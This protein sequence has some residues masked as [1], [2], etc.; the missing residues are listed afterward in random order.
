M[1]NMSFKGRW[2]LVTGASSGLGEAMA[3]Q[4]AAEQAHLMLVARRADKLE[5]LKDELQQQHGIDCRVL[6]ADL[7]QENEIERLHREAEAIGPVYGLILNAGITHFGPHTDLSWSG[8][9]QLLSTNV[10]SVVHLIERFLPAMRARADGS[11]I[12]L[13][14]SLGGLIPVPLQA[15]YSG[16][17]GF[18]CNFGLA[19]AEELRKEAV[20]VTVYC[21][22]GIETPMS[23]DSQLKF[24]KNTPFMQDVDSC[25]ADGLSAMRKR[26]SLFVPGFLNRAQL[27]ATRLAPRSLVNRLT[28]NTYLR[29]LNNEGR[30]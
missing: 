9:E 12:M 7:A 2:V 19:L 17:K 26:H 8:M 1:K 20:S 27:F 23:L 25:A 16:S 14:S 6:V 21:P 3:K 15:L 4:L 30:K 29:A 28:H 10:T 13:V 11:G 24:F 18:V 5:A 22:G